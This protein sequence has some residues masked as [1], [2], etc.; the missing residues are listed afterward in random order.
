PDYT[1][2]VQVRAIKETAPI[3][4]VKKYATAWLRGDKL[5]PIVVTADGY[6][7]DGATRAGGATQAK[8]TTMPAFVLNASW[9]NAPSMTKKRLKSLGFALNMTHGRSMKTDNIES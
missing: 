6:V 4:E 9:E 7:G 1:R 5:P 3:M 8:M 2:R